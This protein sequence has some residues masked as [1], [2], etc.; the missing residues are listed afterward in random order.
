MSTAQSNADWGLLSRPQ[1]EHLLDQGELFAR[2]SFDTNNLKPASYDLRIATDVMATPAGRYKS[3]EHRT[4]PVVLESG[5]VALVTSAESFRLPNHVA[6][7]IGVKFDLASRGLLIHTGLLIHPGYGLDSPEGER[8]HFL[9]GNLSSEAVAFQPGV[10]AIASIQFFSLAHP[11]QPGTST[12]SA[13]GAHRLVEEYV[14]MGRPLEPLS[15]FGALKRAETLANDLQIKVEVI[16]KGNHTIIL[17][18]VY[19]L[20]TAFLGVVLTEIIAFLSS[21]AR[22]RALN[23]AASRLHVTLASSLVILAGAIVVCT[24]LFCL[25]RLLGLALTRPRRSRAKRRR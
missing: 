18:G 21:A 4:S 9:I 22:V 11:A 1:L 14:E 17:F 8:I 12:V 3:G 16:E 7:N 6:A 13:R 5:E 23:T 10:D 15:L 20:A 25:V 2:N 19:L 24:I